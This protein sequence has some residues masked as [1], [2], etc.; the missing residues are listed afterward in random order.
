MIKQIP[1]TENGPSVHC[2]GKFTYIVSQ[3]LNK[4]KFTLWKKLE[5]GYE[6]IATANSPL[7]LYEKIIWE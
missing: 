1:K 6:K 3:N 5:D 7:D 2:N 4:M